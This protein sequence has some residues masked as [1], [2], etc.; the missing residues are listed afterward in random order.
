VRFAGIAACLLRTA[1]RIVPAALLV[2]TL[3]Y[4]GIGFYLLPYWVRTELTSSLAAL[5]GGTA[6]VGLVRFNPFTGRFEAKELRLQSTGREMLLSVERFLIDVDWA[7]SVRE[8]SLVVDGRVERPKVRIGVDGEGNLRLAGM[9]FGDSE[10]GP[11]E[12]IPVKVREFSIRGGGIDFT[13]ERAHYAKRLQGVEARLEDFGPNL[14][15]PARITVQADSQGESFAVDAALAL[16]PIRIHGNARWQAVDLRQFAPYLAGSGFALDQ[17][18]LA[19]DFVFDFRSTDAGIVLAV[20]K[21]NSSLAEA[22]LQVDPARNF[23]G[24]IPTLRV[25]ALEYDSVG[26]YLRVG[27]IALDRPEIALVP[28]NGGA[29]WTMQLEKVA[30]VGLKGNLDRLDFA[31]DEAVVPKIKIIQ[32]SGGD[33]RR[34]ELGVDRFVARA[35]AADGVGSKFAVGDVQVAKVSLTGFPDGEG[36]ESGIEAGT[37][38]FHDIET[39]VTVSKISIGEATGSDLRLTGTLDEEGKPRELRIGSVRVWETVIDRGQ[40]DLAVKAI[41]SREAEIPTW[42]SVRG[43]FHL[44]G[45]P[46]LEGIG[47]DSADVEKPWSVSISEIRLEAYA[48]D[49]RDETV[50]PSFCWHMAPLNLKVTGLD[51]REGKV[52]ELNLEIGVGERGRIRLQGKARLEPLEADLKVAAD[53]VDLHPFQP[54]LNRA[55]QIHLTK[56]QASAKGDLSYSRAKQKIHFGGSGEIA[57]LVTVDKKDGRDFVHW[58]SLRGEGLI[59]ETSSG[60]PVR[61]SVRDLLVD[62]PYFRAVI[63]SDRTLNLVARLS[64]PKTSGP[65]PSDG[66]QGRRR[67]FKLVIGSL[68]VRGGFSD[69]ADLSLE[70][71]VAIG[72]QNLNG[73]IRGLSSQEDAR[74]DVDIEGNV[75]ETAPVKISGQ[76]NPFRIAAFADIGMRFRNVDLTGLSPYSGKFAGYRIE[77]GKVNLDLHYRLSERNLVATNKIVLDQL[78]LGDRVD[79]PE[80]T[81]LPVKFAL[82][83]MKDSSGR[84]DI[85][86]PIRGNLD[87]PQFSILGL[88]GR[89]ATNLVTKVLRSPFAAM[90]VLLN[91]SDEE[92]GAV[93]F[94]PGS[95]ILE[96]DEQNK[97][98]KIAQAL[99][100]RPAINLEIKGI[101]RSDRDTRVLAERQLLRQLQNARL[102]ELRMSGEKTPT[103]EEPDWA[104]AEYRRLFTQFYR[105]RDPE[106]PEL[107]DLPSGEPGLSGDQLEQARRKVLQGWNIT[108]LD[109]RRLAQARQNIIRG[110]LVQ[111]GVP[112]TRIYL[113]SVEVLEAG[114]EEIK[115]PLTLSG[116]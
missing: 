63:D 97:L 94:A 85:D 21:W 5:S 7:A 45:Y 68:K 49:F 11:M 62:R 43:I 90:G 74:A 112:A 76:I 101:A 33:S 81:S 9:I 61:L 56:G 51:T 4:A 14:K 105:A 87:D 91:S 111:Q 83:L 113:L 93:R 116:S 50:S 114:P 6:E 15:M 29:S 73:T 65:S 10:T 72:I 23:R 96:R 30:I 77:K 107:R 80:A 78:V 32:N 55:T 67:P 98:G 41:E 75:D 89:A 16:A 20:E 59:F 17:G 100:D 47:A 39:N 8:G 110:Y 1:L 88:L 22:V 3:L 35:I 95:A 25:T 52:M 31:V 109:L 42:L 12:A 19:A 46:G 40:R 84:I 48:V 66:L 71:N 37:L 53:G 106:A 70:P 99:K 82:E 86:L 92:A 13:D 102:I 103:A 18:R 34:V 44:P 115:I 27:E 58:Q 79:S 28:R 2:G 64:P 108:E 104:N 38:K 36:N 54:Y 26:S 24:Q 69:F 57:G 60:R